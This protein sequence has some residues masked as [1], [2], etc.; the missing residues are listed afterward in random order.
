MGPLTFGCR[1]LGTLRRTT[2]T[3]GNPAKE[4]WSRW[5]DELSRKGFTL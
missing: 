4:Q 2:K 3:S 1:D 5:F